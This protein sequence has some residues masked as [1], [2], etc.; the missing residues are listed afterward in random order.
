MRRSDDFLLVELHVR[1]AVHEQAAGAIGA[2]EDRDRVAGLV[3]LRG[4][5]E[6][7]RAGADDGDFLA[8]AHLRRLGHDPAFLPAAVDDGALDVLDRDRRRR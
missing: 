2:L 4:G 3:E 5:G 1:D 7:R 8:G 6:T